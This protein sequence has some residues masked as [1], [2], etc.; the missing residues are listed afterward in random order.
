MLYSFPHN[1][2]YIPTVIGTSE[3]DNGVQ[4]VKGMLPVQIGAMGMVILDSDTTNVNLKYFSFDFGATP[5][6]PFTLKIRFYVMAERG[7]E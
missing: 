1:Y 3:F 7:H 4:Q 5:I 6:P 2:G